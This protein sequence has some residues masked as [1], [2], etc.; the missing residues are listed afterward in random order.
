MRSLLAS[1]LLAA[2]A[3]AQPCY[4]FDVPFRWGGMTDTFRST[5]IGSW[6]VRFYEYIDFVPT[7]HGIAVVALFTPWTWHPAYGEQFVRQQEGQ[8]C[9]HPDVECIGLWWDDDFYTMSGD[10]MRIGGGFGDID[11]MRQRSG[12]VF[13]RDLSSEPR[14]ER[15]MHASRPDTCSRPMMWAALMV[16]TRG[17]W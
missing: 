5:H 17:W 13:G 9:T 16:P 4:A 1:V 12:I 11:L 15:L 6:Q 3:A 14:I 7:G 2:A 8:W 10:V